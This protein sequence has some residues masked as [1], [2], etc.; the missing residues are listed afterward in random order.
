M[1]EHKTFFYLLVLLGDVE[2]EKQGPFP[3]EEARNAAA[4][5]HRGK[6]EDARDGLHWMNIT[7]NPLNAEPEVEVGNW[8]NAFFWK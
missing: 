3:T 7:V 1:D 5:Q 2:I 6:D 8:S 4:L